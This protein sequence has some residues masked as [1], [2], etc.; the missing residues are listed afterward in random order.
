M[1]SSWS[2]SWATSWGVSWGDTGAPPE[3]PV[4]EVVQRGGTSKRDKKRK[5]HLTYAEAALRAEAGLLQTPLDALVD[6]DVVPFDEETE[7]DEIVLM[8]LARLLH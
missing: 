4:V 5:R 8:L 2:T 6:A 3:P 1:A 7:D